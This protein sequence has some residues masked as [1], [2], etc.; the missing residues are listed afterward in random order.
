MSDK[1]PK[2]VIDEIDSLRRNFLWSGKETALR[3]KN[4][5]AWPTVCCPTG[6]GGLEVQAL[7]DASVTVQVGNGER[8]LFWRDNWINGSSVFRMAPY[9]FQVIPKRITKRRTVAEAL[10]HRQWIRDIRGRWIWKNWAPQR[11]K[12]FT[13]LALKQ[14]LWTADRRRRHG[15]D[16]HDICWLCDQEQETADHLLVNCSFAKQIW[17]N[18]LSWMDCAC[19]FPMPMELHQWWKHIRQMQVK[20][21]RRGLD[22]L[23][24]LILWCLWKERNARLF[25]NLSSNALEVQDRIKVDIKLWIDAGATRLGCLRHE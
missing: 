2:W 22:T 21:R 9:L 3:G 24:M 16:A 15:L 18:M 19:T 20:E 17:W 23:V 8:T 4:M 5:V 1:L 6:C 10:P 12:F 13:W 7:F 11:V 14:R 25:D